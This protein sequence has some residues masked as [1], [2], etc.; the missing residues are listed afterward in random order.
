METEIQVLEKQ[1]AEDTVKAY[2]AF[3]FPHDAKKMKKLPRDL[4]GTNAKKA[5]LEAANGDRYY[6]KPT[7]PHKALACIAAAKLA[8]LVGR[9]VPVH[10]VGFYGDLFGTF[11]D[12]TEGKTLSEEGA[13]IAT[14]PK[15]DLADI[16]KQQCFNYLVSFPDLWFRNII[17]GPNGKLIYIDYE[18]EAFNWYGDDDFLIDPEVE[19]KAYT[20]NVYQR[21]YRRI[22]S[23]QPIDFASWSEMAGDVSKFASISDTKLEEFVGP[24]IETAL[25]KAPADTPPWKARYSGPEMMKTIKARR[26]S[27]EKTLKALYERLEGERKKNI[28]KGVIG[29]DA[30]ADGKKNPAILSTS[31]MD[32]VEQETI[33]V[34]KIQEFE[35]EA[36]ET[37]VKAEL[38]AVLSSPRVLRGESDAQLASVHL[39]LHQLWD[40]ANAGRLELTRPEF[41]KVHA[42]VVAEM[43]RRGMDHNPH[44]EL[45]RASLRTKARKF[46]GEQ[47]PYNVD[48][49]NGLSEIDR[50]FVSDFA[51]VSQQFP[52]ADIGNVLE[53]GCGVGRALKILKASGIESQG[54]EMSDHAVSVCRNA[55]LEASFGDAA[56]LPYKEGAFDVTFSMD[57]LEHVADFSKAL[58]EAV[59]VA[60]R[61]SI[62]L[63]PLGIRRDATH[64]HTFK[65]LEDLRKIVMEVVPGV[66]VEFHRTGS[67]KA[68]VVI[69]KDKTDTTPVTAYLQDFTIIPGFMSLVGGTVKRSDPNDIDIVW[70]V[71]EPIRG[72]E[73]AFRNL[74]P[75]E[76]REKVHHIY[77]P[78]GPHDDHIALFD[79]VAVKRPAF[80]VEQVAKAALKPLKAFTPLKTG[81]GYTQQEFFTP[82]AF[83]EMWAKP[84][85]EEGTRLA[86]EVKY[87]GY[88]T[89]AQSDGKG[90]LVYFEDSKNDRSEQLAP[91]VNDLKAIGK[92]VILD[93]D[94]GAVYGDG[95]V[96]PRVELSGLISENTKVAEDGSFTTPSG[97]KAWIVGHVFHV[98]YLGDEDLHTLPWEEMRKRLTQLFAGHDFKHL[99]IS[100]ARLVS[101]KADLMDAIKKAS[102]EQ[103]SE[104]AVVKV[105]TTDYPLD[106]KTTGWAKIKNLLEFKVEVIDRKPVKDSPKTY[107]YVVG[108]TDESG[109]LREMG[110]TFNTNV[111]AKPGDILT[112]SAEEVI[113]RYDEDAKT[114]TVTTVVPRVEDLETGSVKAEGVRSI[115][116]RAYKAN[117]L[118][119]NPDVLDRLRADKV[120]SK[121]LDIEAFDVLVKAEGTLSFQEGDE[122]TGILQTHE[123]GLEEFQ[124][125]LTRDFGWDPVVFTANQIAR[126]SEM[127]GKSVAGAYSEAQG[128]RSGDLSDAL[129][130][131]DPATLSK[132]DQELLALARPVSVHTDFRMRPG[133]EDYWEGGEGFTPGNQFQENKFRLM[134]EGKLPPG[135]KILMNF[136]T[137]REDELSDVSKAEVPVRG[138]LA[139]MTIGRGS[140]KAFPPGAVGSTSGAWSRFSI[141]DEFE[142]KAG[143]QD[144]H[145]KEFEFNGKVLDGRWIFQFVPVGADGPAQA[146]GRAWMVSKPSKQT[147]DSEALNKRLAIIL[148]IL[149]RDEEQR[150]VTAVVLKPEQTDAQGDIISP[151]VIEKAAHKFLLNYR[152]GNVVGYMHKDFGRNLQVVESYITPSPVTINGRLIPE[153]AWVMSVKVFDEEVWKG[154]RE[155]RITGFSIGGMAK[156]SKLPPSF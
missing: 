145:Y 41:L 123:R 31:F 23:G 133:K 44:D 101:S 103:G 110:K 141:R 26:D 52:D 32:S 151:P 147:F 38:G 92:P 22:A 135:A 143:V 14:L 102:A 5:L 114:W 154:V 54:V 55:G 59:R 111:D 105:V 126:L 83:W 78:F 4:P 117:V 27:L 132:P 53:I 12:W 61:K 100:R 6:F 66:A 46:M 146:Q 79:L 91:I 18:G 77:N 106:G 75:P 127:A 56:D 153:G 13:K 70:R 118:Q 94:L 35:P 40:L 107:N 28:E 156:V 137:A 81:S 149:K 108:Y 87:N 131:V 17:R 112:L 93:M 125:K 88:R 136:K 9:N 1:A 155:G 80:R 97:K 120:V 116:E 144:K 47:S 25:S 129:K 82:D 86:V 74:L 119:A 57:V 16:Q 68:V 58:N 42:F 48:Y 122:G 15:R 89:V 134:A 121:T 34:P 130:D 2:P 98:L 8:K 140:P 104:G 72:M 50:L 60:A 95:S 99:K 150:I 24:Y 142:W 51:R 69:D 96:V 152:R 138:P 84:F 49:Y 113:P 39:R 85:I 65:T 139:W 115:I 148:P 62:H 90:T 21:I 71:S 33:L 73:L 45:D 63:I 7:S 64:K 30:F 128:G 20:F 29:T 67:N 43:E 19:P 124:S 109:K 36:I 37:R 11:R 3:V 76:V 10:W